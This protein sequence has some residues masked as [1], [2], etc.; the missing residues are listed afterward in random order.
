MAQQ[1]TQHVQPHSLPS[2]WM[3][4]ATSEC[5]RVISVFLQISSECSR[6]LPS[7]WTDIQQKGFLFW[8]IVH[9]GCQG[10]GVWGVSVSELEGDLAFLFSLFVGMLDCSSFWQFDRWMQHFTVGFLLARLRSLVQSILRFPD[11]QSELKLRSLPV[12]RK[13]SVTKSRNLKNNL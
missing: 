12:K 8:Q 2:I 10:L 5:S 7:A 4:R 1:H 3:Y 11:G 9:R 6:V 13:I